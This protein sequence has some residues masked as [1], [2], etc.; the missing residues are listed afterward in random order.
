MRQ[1]KVIAGVLASV[2]L[3]T[4]LSG[5]TALLRRAGQASE[6]TEETE[7]TEKTV[8]EGPVRPQDDFY[9]YVNG[10]ALANAEFEYGSASALMAANSNEVGDQLRSLVNDVVAGSGYAVGT[11][12]YII[13]NA[14][15]SYLEYDI[16]NA[17]VPEDLDQ[18]LH[19]IDDSSS[20]EELQLIDA[21]L[22]RDYTTA[23]FTRLS[24]DVDYI[25]SEPWL[26]SFPQLSSFISVDYKTV[27]E[28]YSPFDDLKD[29]A[30]DLLEAIGH[31]E[32]EAD[33]IGL[34]LG[35]LAVDIYNATDIDQLN[36]PHSYMGYEVYSRDQIADI[37]TNFDLDAYLSMMGPDYAA[38]DRFG[39]FDP[40]QLA[41]LNDLFVEDNLNA[42]K[43]WELCIVAETYGDFMYNGYEGLS[44]Y[45]RL[46]I[47]TPEEQACDNVIQTLTDQTDII[48]IENYYTEEMDQ[49]LR[50]LCDD[51]I[52]EYRILIGDADWLTEETREALIRKLDNIIYITGSNTGRADP[53]YYADLDYSNYYDFLVQYMKIT[54]QKKLDFL[55]EF[56]I[57]TVLVPMQTMNAFYVPN[58]N[59]INITVAIMTAPYFDINADY[60]QNLGGLGM[61]IAHEIGH[62]FDSNCIAFDENGVYNPS[63][64]SSSDSQILKS[65]DEVAV[66]Y[67]E[68]NFTLFGVYHV[69]GERTLG[70]NY[71]DLG[72]MECISRIPET[73]EQRM[74]MYENFARIW[75]QKLLDSSLIHQ[76][77]SDSHSPS[78]IR[79]NGILS[80]IDLF[81][82]T[83]GVTE[84]DGM[85]IPP[86]D[87]IS[88]WY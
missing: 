58:F 85:Y 44:T 78:I 42:L 67:F 65:R 23:G 33:E 36:A 81:Y 70:E 87:R 55:T 24:L 21:R 45:S 37:L 49:E 4:P 83:Y 27:E 20:V 35:Q 32:E 11:E 59:T 52:D 60:Y 15:N 39:I 88:R 3:L 62:A 17:A 16:G 53:S 66:D 30:S 46:L 61:V 47:G 71:A 12:E 29:Y 19:E 68:N 25:E 2:I 86:E 14:Y 75:C 22:V 56:D 38:A 73:N 8:P 82:E 51:I 69:D 79:V 10:E 48:Y 31:S 7:T 34:Q 84:G 80:T 41:G 5:C 1:R 54:N 13:Q 6:T 26:L 74:I 64:I 76:L 57:N 28:S 43:A 63:W 9:R 50:S 77:A 18:L 72:A 40:G